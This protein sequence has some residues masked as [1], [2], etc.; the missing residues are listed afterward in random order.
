MSLILVRPI[1]YVIDLTIK[2][3]W[4]NAIPVIFVCRNNARSTDILKTY[5]SK[6]SRCVFWLNMFIVSCFVYKNDKSKY[7]QHGCI[8]CHRK[9][10]VG[11]WKTVTM[12]CIPSPDTSNA[13]KRFRNLPM[14]QNVLYEPRIPRGKIY[15]NVIFPGYFGITLGLNRTLNLRA[16][17]S[18]YYSRVILGF[19][20]HDC[21]VL[22]CIYQ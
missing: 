14:G 9:W 2:T 11:V 19:A 4:Y 15:G 6:V 12:T 21:T 8:V 10:T 5:M 20:E 1:V 16:P 7:R 22:R 17:L 3:L 13:I 18:R